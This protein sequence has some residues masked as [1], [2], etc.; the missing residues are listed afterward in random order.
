M[1]SL[2]L[3]LAGWILALHWWVN[4]YKKPGPKKRKAKQITPDVP[5]PAAQIELCPPPDA[6][7]PALEA[8]DG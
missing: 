6:D 3:L 2:R 4:P 8:T 1:K 5:E 7:P